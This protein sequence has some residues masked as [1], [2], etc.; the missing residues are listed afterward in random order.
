MTRLAEAVASYIAVMETPT[1]THGQRGAAL[2]ALRKALDSRGKVFGSDDVLRVSTAAMQG[3]L[4]SEKSTS[5]KSPA[6]VAKLAEQ[7]A[8]ALL[9]GLEDGLD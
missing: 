5:R 2:V 8:R 6:Q 9:E 3:I 1:A 7:Y 4:S